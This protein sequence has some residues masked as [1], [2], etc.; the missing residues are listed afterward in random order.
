DAARYRRGALQEDRRQPA[1][2]AQGRARA[3][4]D[5]ARRDLRQDQGSRD[6][7]AVDRREG[8]RHE[9]VRQAGADGGHQEVTRRGGGHAAPASHRGRRGGIIP[10]SASR[11][12]STYTVLPVMYDDIS[13]ARKTATSPISR[14]SATRCIGVRA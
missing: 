9:E 12:P 4:E 13:D 11:P 5:R 7:Q 10:L 6:R 3:E 14:G 1:V 8:G 2:Q